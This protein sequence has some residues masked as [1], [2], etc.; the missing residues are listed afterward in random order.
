MA[1]ILLLEPNYK[2]KYPP[3]GLMKISYYHKEIKKDYVRFAKGTLPEIYK[4]KKWDRVY[5]TTL[6]TFEWE[7]IIKTIEYAK[8]VVKSNDNIFIGGIAASLM[9]DEI[10]NETGIRPVNGLLNEKGKIGFEDDALIDTITPDYSMLGDISSQYTYP[11]ENAYFMY[12]TRGCGMDCGFCAVKILEPNYIS[13]ISIKKQIEDIINKYGEKKDLLLMDNNVL[14]SSQFDLI[15]D[16][17]KAV[18]FGKGATYVNLVTGKRVSRYVD[19][20]QGLDAFLMTEEKAKRLSELAI[21][22]ARIAFDH[23]EDI[24]TYKA[25]VRRCAEYGITELSNYILYNSESFSG[26]GHSYKADTPEELYERIKITIELKDE[27]NQKLPD[28]KKIS[29]FSFPMRYIPLNHKK[30]GYVGS[31]WNMK[32]LRA[33]QVMMMPSQGKGVPG[34]DFFEA[35]FGKDLEE[36]KKIL[37]MPEE[38]I[39]SRGNFTE[40]KLGKKDETEDERIIRKKDWEEKRV[41]WFEWERLYAQLNYQ[42]EAFIKLISDNNFDINKWLYISDPI[43]KKIFIHY[44]S[45]TR[46][47]ALIDSLNSET[48]LQFINSYCIK[49]FPLLFEKISYNVYHKKLP[50]IYLSSYLK[51]FRQVGFEELFK[52]WFKD[53]CKNDY[54]ITS[55]D[56]VKEQITN[57][58]LD[59][60]LVKILKRYYQLGCFN[61]EEIEVCKKLIVNQ[62]NEEIVDI[63]KGNFEKF[64]SAT[65][66][67][68]KG[69]PGELELKKQV[70]ILTNEIYEQLNL[71]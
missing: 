33:I 48:D 32:C 49:E 21:K 68:V 46:F 37:L 38:V 5:V 59:I 63:L 57:F 19:F 25:A 29:I 36:Y 47:L 17:I 28:D 43:I 8:Q 14:K 30:R 4:N 35:D 51:I 2:N 45:Y 11:Y 6:F 18:G 44:L 61:K 60:D 66:K 31:C 52:I 42:K 67:T 50:S 58:V 15:I 1:D 16:E 40:V 55:L 27:I 23:I 71:F 69:L 54:F 34:K 3:L 70:K 22:P 53:E 7:E 13:Q 24:D 9:P 39:A 62:N 12:T 10:Y 20:N 41:F 56:K 64:R 65:L 26:K